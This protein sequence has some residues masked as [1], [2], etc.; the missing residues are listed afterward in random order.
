[1]VMGNSIDCESQKSRQIGKWGSVT[2]AVILAFSAFSAFSRLDH[3]FVAEDFVHALAA[4]SYLTDGSFRLGHYDRE[5]TRARLMTM[6]VAWSF[7][8]FGESEFAARIPSATLAVLNVL[9]LFLIA[10]FFFDNSVAL[11]AAGIFAFQ[12]SL[13]ANGRMV[14]MY[15][16]SL[17]TILLVTW[18]GFILLQRISEFT[19][20]HRPW[21]ALLRWLCG[22]RS[23]LLI[24]SLGVIIPPMIHLHTLSV[25]V[26]P[27]LLLYIICLLVSDARRLGFRKTVRTP[28]Y[29]L[30]C[31][32]AIAV[33]VAIILAGKGRGYFISPFVDVADWAQGTHTGLL[34]NH[35]LLR[36][37]S[38][39]VYAL[40]PLGILLALARGRRAGIYCVCL[41]V[42]AFGFLNAFA[43]K[44]LRFLTLHMGPFAILAGLAASAL[45]G[46][47]MER[48][49]ILLKGK[50]GWANLL[51][52][53][54]ITGAII[55]AGVPQNAL[56][57]PR[58]TPTI[59][60]YR[61]ALEYVKEHWLPSDAVAA[62]RDSAPVYHLGQ[63]PLYKLQAE[64]P[65]FS[66]VPCPQI[67]T[68]EELVRAIKEHGRLWVVL[69]GSLLT[70][71]SRSTRFISPYLIRT[72]K[73]LR[74]VYA[75]TPEGARVY[76]IEQGHLSELPE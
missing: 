44:E 56:H 30:T 12:P 14:R 25:L 50:Q 1:M 9:L 73:S 35:R 32:A 60:G 63:V 5:Y 4:R 59:G 27:G 22:W 6:C 24:V 45:S 71:D 39:P 76:L 49:A 21:Q 31:L 18:L 11:W 26:F 69:R 7:R 20:D 57:G 13:I 74:P 10:R 46:A 55:V 58:S 42:A 52:A 17:F 36:E 67:A 68:Q 15:P 2:L 48:F 8:L 19:H 41:F 33:F 43:W 23:W 64:K 16:H 3:S 62:K 54:A 72:L 51:T 70:F 53:I 75:P 61:D 34:R 38:L 40:L 28:L 29:V 65:I 37:D 66:D 47:I